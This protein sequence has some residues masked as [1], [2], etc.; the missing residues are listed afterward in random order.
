MGRAA[1]VLGKKTF[2]G[3]N[4]VYECLKGSGWWR[5]WSKAAFVGI[6][7]VTIYCVCSFNVNIV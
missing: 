4:V 5:D 7:T 6:R 2:E 1:R 3:R